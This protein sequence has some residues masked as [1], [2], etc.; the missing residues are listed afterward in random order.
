MTNERNWLEA[1]QNGDD[2][3]AEAMFARVVADMPA[4]PP[5]ADF[6]RRT[7]QVA[8]R[9]RARRR[10]VEQLAGVAAALSIGIIALGT[11][12]ESSAR[13][14]GLAV[15]GV[16]LSSHGLIWVLA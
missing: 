13:A 1:E 4:I 3:F 11:L 16:V 2:A 15:R 8:W 14:M 7:V 10:L 5:S 6:V 9:A 12:Y